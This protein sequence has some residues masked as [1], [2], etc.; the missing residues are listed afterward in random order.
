MTMSI[1]SQESVSPGL[2]SR[3]GCQLMFHSQL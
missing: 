1:A 2:A 3:A